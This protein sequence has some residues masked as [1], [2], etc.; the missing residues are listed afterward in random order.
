MQFEG[1]LSFQMNRKLFL[2]KK[3]LRLWY[4]KEHHQLEVQR[5]QDFLSNVQLQLHDQ[6][7]NEELATTERQ[8]ASHLYQLKVELEDVMRQKAKLKWV[9]LG[10]EN[11]SFFHQSIKHRHRVNRITRVHLDGMDITDPYL[12]QD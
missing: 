4:G 1:H 6:P 11:T 12:I 9:Q 7:N 8:V 3:Q 2:L 5:A 10:D